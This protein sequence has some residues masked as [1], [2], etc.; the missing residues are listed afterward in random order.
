M[1]KVVNSVLASAL[2]LTVAP[3]AFAA[4]EAAT[5]TAPK[6][7]ADMEKT[8]KRL[9]ALGLVA[10]Y[11]NGEYGVDKTITR[12][13]FATLVVRARGLEQGAKLAQFSNTYTDVKSTDWFAG[14]VNVA[15]G[16][17][18]VKGF[19]DKSFKPQNQVT[20]AEA[21]T[22]I[23]RALGY[24]PSVKGVWPNSM[25]SKASELN[26][27]RSITTPNNAATRG[28]IFKMLDN[29]LRVDLMEQVEFGT[30]IRH[31][32]TKETL[33]TKYL[34][35]TVRDMEWA[36]EA[37]NDSED[38]PLVTNVPAIGL[39]KIK[40][41]EVT[42]NGKDAG[43]GNTTYKVADG[44]NANDFDGQHVQVWI[45]DDREDVIVW[46]EGST[47]QEVIMDRVGEFTLKGK[48][49]EDP[50]DL[51]NSDLADLKLE[52]DASE[53]SYRF[54]KN[55]KVTYNFTRFN[56]P[57]D[58]L[59]EIIKDNA[60]GGF[61]FG[62]KV[63][64]DNNNEIA[65]IHVIDDQSMNKEDEGVKYGSE[66]ISKID[67]DKKKITNRDN[68]KFN[69]LEDKE[70]GK[71]F[72]VFLN[73]KPAKFS[74]LKEGMVYSVYYADGDEDKL[75]V[76][77]TDTVV[78]GKVD[79]VVS[80]NNND[81][82][83]TIGDKTYRVYEGATF[84]DDGNKDVQDIDKDHWDLVDSLD[85]ETV[86][87]YLDASG[88]VRHIE[89]KDAIDDR[90]QKAIVTRSAVFN[91]SKDTYDFRV[92][93]QKGKEITVSL[94]PKNIY[95]FD[96]KNFARDNKNPDDL[97]EILVP[98]KDKDTLLVEVT[99]DAD[100]KP[101]KVEFL[102]P[103]KVEQESGKAWD[104][105]ADEDDDMVGDY[106]VTDKTAVF[107]M[108]GKLEESSKRKELK[109]AKTA[110]FKDVA[111]ENDLSV[112]Y[113]VNDKDEVEAIFV[114]EGDG[115]T[116]D[117]HYG[118]VIDFGRKGG[119]DT[120]RVWE[121]DG[122]KVVEKEYKLDGDQDDLKDEDIRRNDFIAFT[123]DSNDEV[124]VDDVVEV[125]NK[126]AKGMLAEVTDEKGMKDANIDK[127]VVGLVSDVSK[128]T[129][130]YKDADDN[131]KK[132]SIKSA[133]VYF[134]LYDDFGE[135][136]GVN[137]G[138]YVVM[139]DSGDISGTKYDYVLIVSDEKTVRKDKLE[140]DAEAF[141]KQEPSDGG[142]TGPWDALP[143]KVEGKFTSAGPVKLYRATVELNSKVKA[144]DV[145]AIEFYF[146]G[147]KVEP[148]LLNFKD[149]VITIGYNTEDKVTSS[150][151]KVTNKNGK[152]SDEATVTFVEA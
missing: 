63:V 74:D 114:V 16:E 36:Q 102:K 126:N 87:L 107:N 136:D 27:A 47:D 13:E 110:K 90:K 84:S 138:D 59:K 57:V 105:L 101:G 41:N 29:A 143:T 116:G 71:D 150:K 60:D 131:K 55:T 5:T 75:L 15:S 19:P 42:L 14:F 33:L 61:T 133:T 43:I 120:I 7:D 147:K 144:E 69:D 6:M 3:M 82:R 112:I 117:A 65:Y 83:L 58:G 66:V 129:I 100:G 8:V 11:G 39:G 62:A 95:D 10:G 35:V 73:G 122:D 115:L 4:E 93:T 134:D 132:A 70:E 21:V 49:F 40:A 141:L 46:M 20:Y 137:E 127:M 106:E 2:A 152:D 31:E 67:A 149:G 45:K 50:K 109:N 94:E 99:L 119:K 118:Q 44:I 24:E 79:K 140:D 91:S 89:T 51:S 12:A 146:N 121:K 22:M 9:E 98:S 86:K 130:T 92:L 52:L 142:E 1:K 53:K 25:I 56:D 88:R 77:A 96:G 125:V 30:D 64:L 139:I 26:I 72:L 113:T 80:R 81:Y 28:D 85:D 78:E 76:F 103:V 23:V 135:A 128:D 18:I 17:E 54:N 124:V 38:L 123:V 48:T 151:I 97:E 37:G 145:D 108:T 68:D 32:I 34:K 104:D 111:D 148:S